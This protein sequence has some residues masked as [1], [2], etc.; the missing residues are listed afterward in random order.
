[1]HTHRNEYRTPFL[2]L[3]K[4]IT[5]QRIGASGWESKRCMPTNESCERPAMMDA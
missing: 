5:V 3:T 1:M 2:K 4:P